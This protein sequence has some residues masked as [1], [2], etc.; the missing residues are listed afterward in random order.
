MSGRSPHD[1]PRPAAP[2]IPIQRLFGRPE[3]A[4]RRDDP[5]AIRTAAARGV[6]TPSGALPHLDA[7][8][9][10]FGHH[11]V[12]HL[13]AH[14]SA[15]ASAA[16]A[17]MGAEAFATGDHVVFNSPPGLHTAAHEAAHTVQQRGTVQ[18][19]G[20][21]GEAS[22]RYEQHADAV[23]DLV[24]RGESAQ[25]LLDAHAPAVR[26]APAAGPVQRTLIK[27]GGVPV[28]GTAEEQEVP[29]IRALGSY[30]RME[31]AQV[32]AALCE[33]ARLGKATDFDQLA[34]VFVRLLRFDD[35]SSG[36]APPSTAPSAPVQPPPALAF[37]HPPSGA[38]FPAMPASSDPGAGASA[39]AWAPGRVEAM[40]IEGNRE[41]WWSEEGSE[42][43]GSEAEHSEATDSE[44]AESSEEEESEDEEAGTPELPPAGVK[45]GSALAEA[46]AQLCQLGFESLDPKVQIR[47]WAQVVRI[48]RDAPRIFEVRRE[49]WGD[50]NARDKLI[51]FGLLFSPLVT[52]SALIANTAQYN[53]IDVDTSHDD[54]AVRSVFL[55]DKGERAARGKPESFQGK[56]SHVLDAMRFAH[57]AG[58]QIYL[59][60]RDNEDPPTSYSHE[61]Q[62]DFFDR[63]D[64]VKAA[65]AQLAGPELEEW[66]ALNSM[67]EAQVQDPGRPVLEIDGIPIHEAPMALVTTI[68]VTKER[69]LFDRCVTTRMY[70]DGGRGMRCASLVGDRDGVSA[71]VY[72]PATLGLELAAAPKRLMTMAPRDLQSPNPR[73]STHIPQYLALAARAQIVA[74]YVRIM[75]ESSAASRS[76][77]ADIR[78]LQRNPGSGDMTS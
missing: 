28:P 53:E 18:L 10:S 34:L 29:Y 32:E 44:E 71:E 78:D 37:G 51:R 39:F 30:S 11:D 50:A 31:L 25:A 54:I 23:A 67:R 69:S 61:A 70:P 55:V 22:D 16:A 43:R 68:D 4:M 57:Q 62:P 5:E 72:D 36:A 48:D 33:L 9:R 47:V 74:Q 66:A 40:Q 60:M 1:G 24:V 19:A 41:A 73:K 75:A 64:S 49:R 21:V 58:L 17:A 38:P 3:G 59:P 42:D 56:L 76:G 12:S 45:P 7:I 77:G 20:G 15:E 6:D 65:R 26:S 52:P 2:L 8:Q 35:G 46:Y 27:V 63:D 13:K 14:V